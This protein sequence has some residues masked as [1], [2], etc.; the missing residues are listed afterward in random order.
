MSGAARLTAWRNIKLSHDLHGQFV[1]ASK[2]K[3][4]KEKSEVHNNSW[5]I[6]FFIIKILYLSTIESIKFI[7]KK[8]PYKILSIH[9]HPNWVP[10][11]WIWSMIVQWVR[12]SICPAESDPEAGLWLVGESMGQPYHWLISARGDEM[13][14]RSARC[15]HRQPRFS[16]HCL[17]DA[18]LWHFQRS[19][20]S[21]LVYFFTTTMVIACLLKY[22]GLT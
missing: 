18:L 20:P 21:F 1:Y 22:F 6:L 13:N 10:L 2:S 7:G 3:K 12:Y 9:S 17:L 19:R 16:T 15:C 14:E 8:H 11:I 4:T 5:D